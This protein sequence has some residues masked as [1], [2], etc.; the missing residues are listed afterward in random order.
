MLVIEATLSKPCAKGAN[1]AER[2]MG[3]RRKVMTSTGEAWLADEL[4][5]YVQTPS[6]FTLSLPVVAPIDLQ[7][8]DLALVEAADYI[9]WKVLRGGKV[10]YEHNAVTGALENGAAEREEKR[11]RM[12]K[13]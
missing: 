4:S 11:E 1:L 8:G 2:V 10:I 5:V 9:V 12:A 7:G 3:P 13:K 6:P